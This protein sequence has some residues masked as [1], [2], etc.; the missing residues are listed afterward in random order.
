MCACVCAC[1]RACKKPY[2]SE[3]VYRK[4]NKH[5]ILYLVLTRPG[6]YLREIVSE[7]STV[8]GLDIT[9]SAVCKFLKRI[10][11]THKVATYALQR[12]DTLGQQFVSDV[13]LHNCETLLFVDETG[14]DRKDAIR[15]YGYSL[16]GKPLKAQKLLVHGEHISCIAAISMQGIVALKI[17]RGSVD[18]DTILQ[19]CMHIPSY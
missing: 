1:V 7:V 2:P 14:T 17:A 15:K 10:G 13:S 8:L 16:R 11:F 18:G 6:I 4:I 3:R 5:Y 19:L 12:D 9:E